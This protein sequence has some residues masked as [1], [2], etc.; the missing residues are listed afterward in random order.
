M[1]KYSGMIKKLMQTM[2]QFY[3]FGQSMYHALPLVNTIIAHIG[4]LS[5]TRS[6]CV[7][8]QVAIARMNGHEYTHTQKAA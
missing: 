7:P 6:A 4:C 2:I 5:I 8:I 1:N 3:I